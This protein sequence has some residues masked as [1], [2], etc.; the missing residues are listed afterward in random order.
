MRHRNLTSILPGKAFL[1]LWLG[2][3]GHADL[4]S[5]E[6]DPPLQPSFETVCRNCRNTLFVQCVPNIND[7]LCEKNVA[8]N[9]YAVLNLQLLYL[10][11]I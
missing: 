3:Y 4:I 6:N 11:R 10:R 2:P 5:L 7:S 9:Q 8:I 1:G